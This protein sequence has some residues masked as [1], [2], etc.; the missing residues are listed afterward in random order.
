MSGE[1]RGTNVLV[2]G[3][4]GFIA[5]NLI[6]RLIS[7]GAKVRATIFNKQPLLRNDAVDYIRADLT[8]LSQFGSVMKGID[9]VFMCAAKA[10][11]L[12]LWTKLRLCI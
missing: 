6:P 10:Q 1:L 3:G 12:R 5:S 11:A 2:T 8:D 9:A 7:E 4:A